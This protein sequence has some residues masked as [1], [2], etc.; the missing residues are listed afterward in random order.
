M[1]ELAIGE[2]ARR[3]GIRP[4]ALRYYESIGLLAQPKRVHGHAEEH[5]RIL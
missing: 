2:V 4:L 1:E 5:I 3:A